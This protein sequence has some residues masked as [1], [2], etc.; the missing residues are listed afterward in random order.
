MGKDLYFHAGYKTNCLQ[1]FEGRKLCPTACKQTSV[2]ILLRT[3]FIVFINV[4]GNI[5]MLLITVETVFLK[6]SL[7]RYDGSVTI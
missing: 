6:K 3:C 5:V 4:Y 7:P 2:S 1:L